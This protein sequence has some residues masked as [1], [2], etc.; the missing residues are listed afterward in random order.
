MSITFIPPTIGSGSTTPLTFIDS[1]GKQFT[2]TI[3]V[4]RNNDGSVDQQMFMD[5]LQ[6]QLMGVINKVKL[7]VI[8]FTTGSVE[9]IT[10]P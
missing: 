8:T 2:R 1:E 4:P 10:T 7:G 5:I 9:P 6:G 3:N